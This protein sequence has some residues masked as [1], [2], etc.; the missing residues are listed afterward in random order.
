MKNKPTYYF[1]LLLI[2]AIIVSANIVSSR[3]FLR[4]DLT[5]DKRY[6]LSEATLAILESV[7]EP[8]TVTAFFSEDLPPAIAQT[9]RAFKDL[10]IEYASRTRGCVVYE[11]VNPSEDSL[12]EQQ[13]YEHDIAPIFLS[14][15]EKN[16]IKQQKAFLGAVIRMGDKKE[17]I[18]FMRPGT[19]ME[20]ALSSTIKKLVAKE[21]T[22][23]VYLK[24]HGEPSF[25]GQPQ[26]KNAIEVL[27]T[28]E[29]WKIGDSTA[30]PDKYRTALIIN[31][32]S[33]FPEEHLQQ[34]DDFLAK[35]KSLLIAL[36][37]VKGDLQKEK[38]D[39]TT[40][41]LEQW[42]TEK[43]IEIENA[44]AID[45]NS[46]SMSIPQQKGTFRYSNTIAFPYVPV[47]KH[48]DKEHPI[49]KGLELVI[50][51]FV[52]PINYQGDTTLRF[53]P[54]AWTSEKS[55]KAK[56]PVYFDLGKE[57]KDHDFS[58]S[59][60]VVAAALEGKIVGDKASKVVVFAN[61]DFAYE[62]N[63]D[64][65]PLPED[66]MK[67]ILNTIEWLSDDTGLINLRTK[68]IKARPLDELSIRTQTLLQYLN[69]LLP[70]V[71]VVMYGLVRMQRNWRIRK[72]RAEESYD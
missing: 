31:P 10:L 18:P 13:A 63:T 64:G 32:M 49:T 55:G 23:V 11:F 62:K 14:I 9:K 20:F 54:L 21:K 35:G 7:D 52:S 16:Q 1:T 6:T 69:F 68:G 28:Y 25:H 37:R 26:L 45:K 57:W 70:V 17:C 61:G 53:I 38:G 27:H 34:M 12:K 36:S 67:L 58:D 47:I 51:P 43:G 71:L 39:S 22:N 41:G 2:I 66:N 48:F 59:S 24:G 5:E 60:L 42:L 3:F 4:L 40:T 29:R 50:F 33:Q 30:I 65:I 46:I 44:F 72:Q 19:A 15:R 8:I 56:L